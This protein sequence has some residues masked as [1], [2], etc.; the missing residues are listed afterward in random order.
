MWFLGS[1]SPLSWAVPVAPRSP[2]LSCNTWL[3]S[4][5]RASADPGWTQSFACCAR[6]AC[7]SSWHLPPDCT[8][9]SAGAS[10]GSGA[11]PA[12]GMAT[13]LALPESGCREAGAGPARTWVAHEVCPGLHGM[14]TIHPPPAL[15]PAVLVCQEQRLPFAVPWAGKRWM[16]QL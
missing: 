12:K 2:Q 11:V 9:G 8:S 5:D 3:P 4:F 10:L 14:V 16:G 13:L 6:R 1:L 7:S 15:I